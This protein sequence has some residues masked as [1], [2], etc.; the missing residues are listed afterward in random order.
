[1]KKILLILF[2]LSL[3]S[4]LF[5]GNITVTSGSSDNLK[6][7]DVLVDFMFDAD[8]A[9]SNPD[10]DS[11]RVLGATVDGIVQKRLGQALQ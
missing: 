10:S 5:A 2:F 7:T 4:N 8:D 6:V 9:F 3:S 1:M 11:A